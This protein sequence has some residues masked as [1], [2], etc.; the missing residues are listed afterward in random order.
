LHSYIQARSEE[1]SLPKEDQQEVNDEANQETEMWKSPT[2]YNT[3][4]K[5]VLEVQ[6]SA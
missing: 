2:W 1:Q 6:E 4:D 5:S 3:T